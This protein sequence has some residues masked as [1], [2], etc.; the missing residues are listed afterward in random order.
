MKVGGA[1]GYGDVRNAELLQTGLVLGQLLL[2]VGS[3]T[4]PTSGGRA[5]GP[6]PVDSM[7]AGRK[8]SGGLRYRK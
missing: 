7:S 3:M 5:F 6:R 1:L 2:L 4:W 8:E